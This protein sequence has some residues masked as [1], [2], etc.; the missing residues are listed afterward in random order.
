MIDKTMEEISEVASKILTGW[1]K[2]KTRCCA[3]F[4]LDLDGEGYPN[5]SVEISED[6]SKTFYVKTSCSITG[7][8][9]GTY[10]KPIYDYDELVTHL[11]NI[12]NNINFDMECDLE[13]ELTSVANNYLKGLLD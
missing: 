2:E 11:T 4:T 5:L 8:V 9:G 13:S 3:R 10:L 1:Q 7:Y 12:K 6:V